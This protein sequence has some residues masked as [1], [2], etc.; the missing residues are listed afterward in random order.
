MSC[1][2]SCIMFN[3][4]VITFSFIHASA[5][6]TMHHPLHQMFHFETFF[7][8]TNCPICKHCE[9]IFARFDHASKSLGYYAISGVKDPIHTALFR[10]S[11]LINIYVTCLGLEK[12][13]PK[14][15]TKSGQN[16]S[17]PKRL[18]PKQPAEPTQGRND[19]GSKRPVT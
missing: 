4:I 11:I 14:R 1:Y 15:H 16:D 5:I 10:Y 13:R 19:S 3:P 17:R 9:M 8:E 7:T 18:G 12:I 6:Q 2:L